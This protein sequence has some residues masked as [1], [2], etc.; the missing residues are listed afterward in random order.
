MIHSTPYNVT[1]SLS[2]W[3]AADLQDSLA[4]L[5]TGANIE[6]AVPGWT[7]EA[8]EIE[9]QDISANNQISNNRKGIQV[10]GQVTLTAYAS[11]AN[12]R[13]AG[14]QLALMRDE[15]L[16]LARFKE[17]LGITDHRN[18]VPFENQPTQDRA[19]IFIL[20][21]DEDAPALSMQPD[22]ETIHSQRFTLRYQYVHESEAT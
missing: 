7:F 19:F 21:I 9:Q 1:K 22:N 2:A 3:L 5:D 15:I 4:T 20:N 8:R 18:N 11:D 10:T 14:E 16:T 12:S 13:S 6:L 17:Y